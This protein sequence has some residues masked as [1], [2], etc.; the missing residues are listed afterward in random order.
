LEASIFGSPVK[1]VEGKDI[2]AFAKQMRAR[3]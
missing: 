3:L 2:L 1:T